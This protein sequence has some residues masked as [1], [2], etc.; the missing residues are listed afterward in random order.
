MKFEGDLNSGSL[1]NK[2]K[3]GI[4]N[5][6]HVKWV[7]AS[8]FRIS[9][10]GVL[11]VAGLVFA[12]K[13]ERVRNF[14][15]LLWSLG[16]ESDSESDSEE[17]WVVPGLQ[18]LGNNCFLNVILQALASCS[19]FRS[20]LQNILDEYGSLSMEECAQRLSLTVAL[21][22][23][24][25][26][27]C[28]VQHGR[29]VLS[30]RKVM[31][32]MDH[33]LSNFNLTSQ[34]DAEEAF[35]HLLSSLREEF[36]ECYV[37]NHCSLADVTAFSSR[38]IFT[39]ERGLDQ[40]E[41]KRWKQH[42]LGPFDGIIC[43]TLTCQSCSYQISSDFEFFH[44][45]LLS[46]A[47][48]NGASMMAA[49]T[50]EYCL[51]QFIVAEKVEHYR[52]SRCWHIAAIKYLSLRDIN[53]TDIEKLRC[54]SKEDPCACKHLFGLEALPWSNSFSH[55]LKQLSIA[56]SPK[57]LCIHL[58]RASMDGFG[59]L[60]KLQGHIS[61]PL[62][63]DLTPFMNGGVGIKNWENNFQRGQM[64]QRY[65]QYFPYTNRFNMQSD[66]SML[67]C[68]YEQKGQNISLGATDVEE[69]RRIANPLGNTCPQS[70]QEES[71][72]FQTE[73]CSNPTLNHMD[74]QS[75][76]K[77]GGGTC[78]LVPAD[79]HL[80]RL[81][82]VVEHFGKAG[83]GHYI[84]YRRARA[85]SGDEDPNGQLKHDPVSWFSISDSEVFRVS[86]RDVLSAE[87]SLLFYEK[88]VEC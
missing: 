39:L 19:C 70:S 15:S 78:H 80:Y 72:L 65:Q 35:L 49:C 82:S 71:K 23:L 34:Q 14:N 20:S 85:K 29:M 2:F 53:E 28:G 38:R 61:F 1:V 63:L 16:R 5:L 51:K 31:L 22:S 21:A 50:L 74:V 3:H 73:G 4:A 8:G 59:E 79:F 40:S 32:A 83:S 87:A 45:L 60:V 18:N 10:A 12:I 69:W 30:P 76:D 7:S 46:P 64:K 81:V 66:T 25:E 48:S 86:E 6:S 41:H 24:L 13:D 11:G 37:P 56:H 62:I 68:I 42:F 17:F 36:F 47:L 52:C 88:I 26:E 67:N 33:Y 27:L 54:C 44:S 58:Q 57:V 9:V 77:L 84:V 75:E 55:V 43:S